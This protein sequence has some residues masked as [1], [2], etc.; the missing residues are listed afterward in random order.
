MS[1]SLEEVGWIVSQ[2]VDRLNFPRSIYDIYLKTEP[3]SGKYQAKVETSKDEVY[4]VIDPGI[5]FKELDFQI[6]RAM[7]F[8]LVKKGY[9]TKWKELK[10]WLLIRFPLLAEGEGNSNKMDKIEKE[11]K[12]VLDALSVA[13]Y[14]TYRPFLPG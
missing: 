3:V 11:N 1:V 4:L 8:W 10:D 5:K 13:I 9:I 7:I 6:G 2:W 14:D 12:G